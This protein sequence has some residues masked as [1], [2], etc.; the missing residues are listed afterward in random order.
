MAVK[1]QSVSD[2]PHPCENPALVGHDD[3][4]ASFTA[5]WAAR[6]KYPIHHA[7]IISGP[8]G[9]GKAT[10]A[11]GL[12]RIILGGA[13]DAAA[14]AKMRDGGFG[15]FFVIDLDHNID[16]DGR[17]KPDSKEISVYTIRALIEKLQ[18]TSLTGAWRVVLVDALDELN[19]NAANAFLKILEEPPEKTIFLMPT[20]RLAVVLA[21]LRSRSR[22]E[23]LRPLTNAQLR[24]LWGRFLPDDDLS[25][26]LL[27]ISGGCFGRLG[28]MKRSGAD[29][30]FLDLTALCKNKNSTPAD[31]LAL[32]G[33]IAKSPDNFGIFCDA[34]ANFGLADLYSE[35]S[36]DLRMMNSV[37]LNPES[38][39][40]RLIGKLKKCL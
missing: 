12:A 31:A 27:K 2:F 29:E 13:N 23:K 5:A 28:A 26:E 7:W 24:T 15:D 39:A 4:I 40:F 17:P 22:V 16:K 8:R 21:T 19:R 20:H 30:L 33:R 1:K 18:K 9:I 6:E 14:V 10:A 11:Y 36:A 34:A 25:A 32:A 3:F 35:I 37:N 38:T